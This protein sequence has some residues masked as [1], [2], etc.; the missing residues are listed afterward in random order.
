M[1]AE[2]DVSL[3]PLQS[4][5]APA[6]LV[7]NSDSVSVQGPGGRIYTLGYSGADLTTVTNPDGGV[8]TYSYDGSHKLVGDV[9]GSLQKGWSYGLGDGESSSPVFRE[10]TSWRTAFHGRDAA[11]LFRQC[12]CNPPRTMEQRL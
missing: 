4:P 9:I 3:T 10:S 8:E 7:Y 11:E 12:Y 6:S 5:T 1:S 2:V